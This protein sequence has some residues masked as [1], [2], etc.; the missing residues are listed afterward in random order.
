MTHAAPQ[1]M[2]FHPLPGKSDI[3]SLDS[4]TLLPQ[5]AQTESF[6]TATHRSH[7]FLSAGIYTDWYTFMKCQVVNKI[8]PNDLNPRSN[9]I[10]PSASEHNQPGFC[11]HKSLLYNHTG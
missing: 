8:T 1:L 10:V 7:I 4:A 2:E 6:V 3:W 11:S 9:I 5:A